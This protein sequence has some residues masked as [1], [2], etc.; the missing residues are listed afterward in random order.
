VKKE[1]AKRKIASFI[2]TS[3]EFPKD[4]EAP[5]DVDFSKFSI[6]DKK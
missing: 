3:A 2:K 5:R 1:I 4:L 6:R